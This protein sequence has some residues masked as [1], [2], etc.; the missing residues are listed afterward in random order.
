MMRSTLPRIAPGPADRREYQS[1]R[2][3]GGPCLPAPS[4]GGKHSRNIDFTSEKYFRNEQVTR[5]LYFPLVQVSG[6]RRRSA[7]GQPAQWR[8]I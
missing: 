8:N 2:P 5:S 6:K 4:P 3:G 1:H 7:P